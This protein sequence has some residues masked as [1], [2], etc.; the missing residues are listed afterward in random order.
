MPVIFFPR[1]LGWRALAAGL[2]YAATYCI[3]GIV[4]A[5][6]APPAISG[7][8]PGALARAD[9]GLG[10]LAPALPAP[11][12]LQDSVPVAAE[13]PPC[14]ALAAALVPPAEQGD[15]DS[16]SRS[17]G[18]PASDGGDE[19]GKESGKEAGKDAGK[20]AGKEAGKAD[21]PDPGASSP[22]VSTAAAAKPPP[23]TIETSQ[24]PADGA[25]DA[26]EAKL[27]CGGAPLQADNAAEAARQYALEYV[28]ADPGAPSPVKWVRPLGAP[29]P[30]FSSVS[31]QEGIVLGD[32]NLTYR[33]TEGPS[34]SVGAMTPFSPAW[35][36]AASIGGV[37]VSNLNAA[38]DA[39]VPEGKLGYS[40]MF[41]R[42]DNTD[43]SATQGGV[44]YGRTA[45]TGSL[46]YGLTPDLT[47]ESQVQTATSL[48]A[49]GVGTTY[50]VGPWGTVQAGVI[51]SRFD[52][53]EAMRYHLGYNVD[54]LDAL[55]L[56]YSNE[57]TGA[58]YGDLSTYN[59][60]VTPDRQIRNTFSAGVPVGTWGR[61]SGTYSGLR[62]A[63][64]VLTERRYGLSQS[65]VVGPGMRFAVGA[66]HDT[67]SGDYAVNVQL[68]VPM[69]R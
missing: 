50:S 67:V 1:A 18:S 46:R 13:L 31:T 22:D 60:G 3:G 9:L 5:L 32:R 23:A 41:G 16:G 42:I 47:L 69:G 49:T 7:A 11:V 14:D 8:A 27:A 48:N 17:A 52:T 57:Q 65:V 56:G 55:T 62:E 2:T 58:G 29:K 21:I 64:G 51:Q 39:T 6:A 12:K 38:S 63:D 66:D 20:E 54:L 19:A 68:T 34:L 28:P 43:P 15:G 45:G 10:A 44:D 4:P 26:G 30:W 59:T 33:S 24:V 61:L 35:G 37:Q 36:S 25:A 53:S 40:S